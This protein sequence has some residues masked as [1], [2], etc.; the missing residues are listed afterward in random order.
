MS[1]YRPPGAY[2][3]GHLYPPTGGS[4]QHAAITYP[5][6]TTPYSPGG[7]YQSPDTNPFSTVTNPWSPGETYQ[8]SPSQA[9]LQTGTSPDK[10]ASTPRSLRRVAT[11]TFNDAVAAIPADSG[12]DDVH[13]QLKDLRNHSREVQRRT[14]GIRQ[15]INQKPVIDDEW[16][17]NFDQDVWHLLDLSVRMAQ[18]GAKVVAELNETQEALHTT[19]TKLSASETALAETRDEV[20]DLRKKLAMMEEDLKGK[21]GTIDEQKIII[22]NANKLIASM[23]VKSSEDAAAITFLKEKYEEH[24]TTLEFLKGQVDNKRNL[25]KDVHK[26]QDPYDKPNAAA[27]FHGKVGPGR[28]ISA[29]VPPRLAAAAAPQ[30]V[31]S[32]ATFNKLAVSTQQQASGQPNLTAKTA[33]FVPWIRAPTPATIRVDETGSPSKIQIPIELGMGTLSINSADEAAWTAVFD[34]IFKLTASFCR[35]YFDRIPAIGTDIKSHIKTTNA[36]VWDFMCA[37]CRT[38][39]TEHSESQVYELLSDTYRVHFMTR[40]IVQYIIK[41]MLSTEGWAGYSDTVNNEVAGLNDRLKVVVQSQERQE[42]VE[43]QNQIYEEIFKSRQAETFKKYKLDVHVTALKKIIS[44]FISSFEHGSPLARN[45]TAEADITFLGQKAWDLSSRIWQSRLTF[46]YFWNDWGAKFS[47]DQHIAVGFRHSPEELM[48]KHA[49]IKLTI[50]PAVMIRSD[51]ELTINATQLLK[52][53][54][55]LIGFDK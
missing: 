55:L 52:S 26:K 44:P 34:E 43:R 29:F 6:R 20:L 22:G 19:R 47:P 49:R 25:W 39:N 18:A 51:E 35:V 11:R 28:A 5:A 36:H 54:V 50:T 48:S 10:N 7:N 32:V 30:R 16:V 41:H 8:Y 33:S 46:Q 3:T 53:Q 40:L 38:Q 37:V 9:H 13:P 24:K 23:E 14:W 21:Q 42:I 17:D 1:N 31:A 45:R 15:A 12:G 4:Y 2:P 27:A